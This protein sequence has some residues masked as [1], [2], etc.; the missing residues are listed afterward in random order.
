MNHKI[1]DNCPSGMVYECTKHGCWR[2][3]EE[4]LAAT[5][6]RQVRENRSERL[7][8]LANGSREKCHPLHSAYYSMRK[9][10][11]FVDAGISPFNKGDMVVKRHNRRVDKQ[12]RVFKIV[13]STENGLLVGK[14]QT[15]ENGAKR[16]YLLD[17]RKTYHLP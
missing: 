13:G 1:C 16:C 14:C 10:H 7:R 2:K 15:L 8:I 3:I 12:P 17:P 5:R 6:D 4:H 11:G 9:K